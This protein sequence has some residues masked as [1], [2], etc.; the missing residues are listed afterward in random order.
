ML[1]QGITDLDE[2]IR[3]LAKA[4]PD[5]PI[6]DS[7]PGAGEVMV[8]RLI[9]AFGTH[10]DRFSNASQVQNFSGIAPVTETKRPQRVDAHALGLLE[11]HPAD[12]SRMGR[13][14]YPTVRVGLV[15]IT[16]SNSTRRT[17]TM[18]LPLLGRQVDPDRIPMLGQ[19]YAL[20][21]AGLLRRPAAARL[22]LGIGDGQGH[23]LMTSRRAFFS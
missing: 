15:P 12:V 22:A 6:F 19:P 18:P 16:A 11:V 7:Q 8:P 13:P 5:Y 3:P 4:H 20:Q 17:A 10:R 14:L 23:R 1:N 21:R 2:R 9:A